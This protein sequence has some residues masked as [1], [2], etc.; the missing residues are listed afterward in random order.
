MNW[1]LLHKKGEI[2]LF[3]IYFENYSIRKIAFIPELVN[4]HHVIWVGGEWWVWWMVMGR[5]GGVDLEGEQ[6][7]ITFDK[8]NSWCLV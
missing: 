8:R 4:K 5:W 3:V 7:S 6:Q 1:F 2:W